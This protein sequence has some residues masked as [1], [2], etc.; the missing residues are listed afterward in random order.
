LPSC[1]AATCGRCSGYRSFGEGR[2]HIVGVTSFGQD[3]PL[4]VCFGGGIADR[5]DAFAAFIAAN[6]F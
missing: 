1:H 2:F 5:T 3:L 6:T 4:Q